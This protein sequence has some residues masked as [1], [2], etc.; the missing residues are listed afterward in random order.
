LAVDAQEKVTGLFFTN[1]PDEK[2]QVETQLPAEITEEDV[3]VGEGEWALPG[4]LTLPT[5][6]ADFPAVVLVHGSGANDRDETVGSTKMFR[7]LAWVL[8]KNGIA[9]IRYDKRTLVHASQFT[10]ELQKSGTVREET[11]IDAVLAGNVLKTD[12]RINSTRIFVAGHSLGAMLGPR[13]AK[14]SDG[15]FAGM[16]LMSGSPLKLTDIIITQ[17]EDVLNKL[18]DDVRKTQQPLLD[19]EV[20]KLA[21]LESM[22]EEQAMEATAFG[23]PGCYILDLLKY[24]AAATLKELKLPTFILQ[25]GADFQISLKNGYEAWQTA[26]GGEAYVT[27]KLYPELNHLLMKYTGD[28]ANQYSIQEYNAPASLDETVASDIVAWILDH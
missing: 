7:D 12:S 28:P 11:I 14:E 8:A 16:V 3:T 24:D 17:N 23:L 18:T 5:T 15:L 4:I 22:T 6:G 10:A 1:L 9:S 2:T 26:A 27:L 20:A 21:A 25:G 13:I 19:A